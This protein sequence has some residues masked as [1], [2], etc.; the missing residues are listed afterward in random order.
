[1]RKDNKWTNGKVN[2]E[3]PSLPREELRITGCHFHERIFDPSVGP[4]CES[5]EIYASAQSIR[6]DIL[7]MVGDIGNSDPREERE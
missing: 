7:K 4:E 1:M 2:F 5:R 6:Q 3:G